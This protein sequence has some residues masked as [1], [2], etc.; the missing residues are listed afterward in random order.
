MSLHS[1]FTRLSVLAAAAL[2]AATAAADIEVTGGWARETVPGAPAAGYLV[3]RNTGDAPRKLMRLTTPV[4]SNLMLHRSSVDAQG[5][6]RM[7]PMASF[8]IGAG[9]TVRFEPNGRH[10]MFMDLAAPFRAGTPVAVTLEFSDGEKPVTVMLD[11]RP[12]PR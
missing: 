7:W 11:V 9:E 5:I 12:L 2:Y 6:A 10:L 8:E 3:I 4:T 1:A